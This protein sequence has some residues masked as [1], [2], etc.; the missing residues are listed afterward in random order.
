MISTVAVGSIDKDKHAAALDKPPRPR[1]LLQAQLKGQKT[2]RLAKMEPQS[3]SPANSYVLS[4]T[5]LLPLTL[6]IKIGEAPRAL[7]ELT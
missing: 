6:L 1:L 5:A 7:M 4:A 2:D 3:T